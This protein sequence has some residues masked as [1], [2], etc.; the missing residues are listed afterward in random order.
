VATVVLKL[1][2]IAQPDTAYFGEKDA[3]QLAIIRRLVA[4]FNLPVAIVGVP[5]V[6]EADGLAIS[7]RNVHLSPDERRLAPA[8]IERSARPGI[9]SP[10]GWPT[11]PLRRRRR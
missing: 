8:C 5:T 7:S 9:R 4:D 10:P 3:Q 11:P 6:R 1:L 2:E